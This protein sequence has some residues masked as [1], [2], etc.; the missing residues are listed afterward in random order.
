MDIVAQAKR[1]AEHALGARY[2]HFFIIYLNAGQ[3]TAEQE[4][5]YK[6]TFN[7]EVQAI[8]DRRWGPASKVDQ[9]INRVALLQ[10]LEQDKEK[11]KDGEKHLRKPLGRLIRVVMHHLVNRGNPLGQGIFFIEERRDG[12]VVLSN[13]SKLRFFVPDWLSDLY[14]EMD[15]QL[16]TLR[17]SYK[18]GEIVTYENRTYRVVETDH[19]SSEEADDIE[20]GWDLFDAA[21]PYAELELIEEKEEVLN[22]PEDQ[23]PSE[24]AMQCINEMVSRGEAAIFQEGD[25]YMVKFNAPDSS[26]TVPLLSLEYHD[27]L[28]LYDKRQF[29]DVAKSQ[30]ML[31]NAIETGLFNM[32]YLETDKRII[33][34]EKRD[35]SV[36]Y[37]VVTVYARLAFNAPEIA[38]EVFRI[39]PDPLEHDPEFM[40]NIEQE[41]QRYHRFLV[42]HVGANYSV[43]SWQPWKQ[44]EQW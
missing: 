19:I 18:I 15:A 1:D 10:E 39:Y 9:A 24:K 40:I 28:G 26:E 43:Q 13:R 6:E 30:D 29:P 21:G 12:R 34:H 38:R 33:I 8:E 37:R 16:I 20:D 27:E 5:L 7:H 4:Q 36:P 25:A 42:Q 17:G 23:Q 2:D 3:V 35:A 41:K 14:K 32:A 11:N 31:E 22:I 44:P